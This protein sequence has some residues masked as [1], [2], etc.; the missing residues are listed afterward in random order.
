MTGTTQPNPNQQTD[1]TKET[2]NNTRRNDE[3]II[4][5]SNK[6]NAIPNI[7]DKKPLM[8]ISRIIKISDECLNEQFEFTAIPVMRQP[9]T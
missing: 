5:D 9:K 6:S 7:S 3:I 2:I 1:S 4:I 8:L